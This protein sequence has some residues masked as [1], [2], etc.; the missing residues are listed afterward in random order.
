MTGSI[1]RKAIE[2]QLRRVL[3]SV[4]FRETTRMK[5]FLAHVVEEALEGRGDGLK[6]YALGIDVFDKPDDF[7]PT[8]DTIVRVQANKLRSRL[9][10]Y[11]ADEGRGDPVRIHIPKGSY[12]PVFEIA[13]DPLRLAPADLPER[14]DPRTSLAIMPFDNLS[15][16]PAQDYMA[17]GLTEEVISALARFREIR[18][19]SRHV[20]H[21]YRGRARDPRDVGADLGVAYLV[22]GSVRH[23]DTVLRVTAQLIDTATGEQ[24]L[25]DAY[26]RDLS[27]QALFQVQDDIAARVAA[28][29]AEPHGHLH[30]AG[31]RLRADTHLLDAYQC[32]L[33][34]TEYWRAPSAAEHLR[35]RDLLERA[36]TLDPDYAGAWGMLGIVYGDEVR[37]GYNPR[38]DAPPF[39]RALAAAERS[40][41][42]DSLNA[43]GLHALFLTH[44]H[45]GNF[46][47]FETAANRA[48]RANPNYPDM[49][50]DLAACRAIR[51][52]LTQGRA[53]S[54]KA[55]LLSPDPPGWYHAG[56]CIAEFAAEEY[57]AALAAARRIGDGMWNGAE[58]LEAM[59]LGKMGRDLRATPL[60]RRLHDRI[61]DLE[62]YL[63]R[64][65]RTWQ[66]PEPL[67]RNVRDGL[68]KAGALDGHAPLRSG[69]P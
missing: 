5:R 21:R 26:D 13:F 28:Q 55:I 63:E 53:L 24:V 44:Y 16:D 6:G 54:E 11:Y 1:D 40:V 20:T 48:L 10:L 69:T 61:P 47:A 37:G 39:V 17:D 60:I 38:S 45:L 3:Q 25:S 14:P 68:G 66:V 52:D 65:F 56:I 51:G 42:L 33:L 59:C 31:A 7:D 4:H 2:E 27:A 19:L 18:V 64:L 15:G 41:A 62:H 34:A 12:A 23:W 8:T 29:I 67:R 50:A 58:V 49:L 57:A 22:E 43:T 32:R 46:D 35:V 36:V 9:D 30:R